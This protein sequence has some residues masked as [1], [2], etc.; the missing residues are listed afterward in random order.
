MNRLKCA[1]SLYTYLI[2]SSFNSYNFETKQG[3]IVLMEDCVSLLN[4]FVI[5]SWKKKFS[6]I[7][8]R[9]ASE[10]WFR[11]TERLVSLK[12]TKL[13]W[14]FCFSLISSYVNIYQRGKKLWMKRFHEKC[15]NTRWSF[16]LEKRPL[17]STNCYKISHLEVV[18]WPCMFSCEKRSLLCRRNISAVE[19]WSEWHHFL[20]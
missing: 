3:W 12:F 5:K 15:V 16:V 10:G 13:Q 20:P 7:F 4:S 19:F 9:R 6:E 8:R 14:G 18:I 11:F 2:M 17:W 1:Y